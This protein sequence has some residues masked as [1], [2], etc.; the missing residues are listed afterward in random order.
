MIDHGVIFDAPLVSTGFQVYACGIS[1]LAAPLGGTRPL[2]TMF[3]PCTPQLPV[4]AD[5]SHT[6]QKRARVHG[7]AVYFPR[8]RYFLCD[9]VPRGRQQHNVSGRWFVHGRA[10]E[11]EHRL[12]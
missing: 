3:S 5:E 11:Q 8:R 10:D 6:V 7:R 2:L 4:S 9:P 12:R 1:A